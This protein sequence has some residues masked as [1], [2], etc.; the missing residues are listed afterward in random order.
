MK[1][2]LLQK[3]N[4]EL[5]RYSELRKELTS[6]NWIRDT[7][8][9]DRIVELLGISNDLIRQYREDYQKFMEEV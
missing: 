2:E 5:A 3:L 7:S 8:E 6:I 4:D 1:T 9:V